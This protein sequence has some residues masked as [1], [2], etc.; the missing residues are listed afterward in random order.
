MF[1]M[2]NKKPQINWYLQDEYVSKIYKCM[3]KD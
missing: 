2:V 1:D 3:T